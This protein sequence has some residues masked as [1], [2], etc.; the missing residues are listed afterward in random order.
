MADDIL[1]NKAAIIE[2]CLKRLH[3]DY[4]GHEAALATEQMRQD[5]VM[6]NLLRA[7]EAAIDMAM[8]VVRSRRLGLPQ[9]SRDAFGLLN[10]AGLLDDDLTHRMKGMVGFR[11]IAVHDY[12]KLDLNIVRAIL[13]QRLDDFRRLVKTL[14]ATD[15]A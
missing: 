9:E 4:R 3:E 11:N 5:A 13:E 12:R 10:N 2:R 14:L 8:H 15:T 7:C 1:L 6:L